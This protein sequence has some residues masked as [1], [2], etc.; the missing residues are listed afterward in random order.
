MNA[1]PIERI[2]C[3]VMMFFILSTIDELSSSSS[4]FVRAV[5]TPAN[6]LICGCT[7]GDVGATSLSACAGSG[8]VSIFSNSSTN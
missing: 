7:T 8:S 6:C 2:G 4:W 5:C 1:D 3:E